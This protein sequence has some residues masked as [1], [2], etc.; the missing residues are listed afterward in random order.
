MGRSIQITYD[1]AK[2]TYAQ[3]VA[4]FWRQIDPTDAGGQFVDQGKQYQSAIFYHSDEQKKIALQ[5]KAELQKSGRF[6]KPIVTEI[7]AATP[8]YKAE[9]YHQDYYK[10][11]P[12]RYNLRP[13][14]SSATPP[15][16]SH[17]F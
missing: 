5:T 2:V 9:E 17:S 10:K 6:K 11:N 3:L 15:R 7:L 8:F 13:S 4:I 12:I 1:P 14:L 16:A